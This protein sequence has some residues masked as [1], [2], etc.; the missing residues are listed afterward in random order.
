MSEQIYAE[1]IL[2]RFKNPRNKGKL[3]KFTYRYRELNSICGDEVEI[4][5][6]VRNNKI[7]NA[8]FN[9]DGCAISQ[10]S[11]DL[12]IDFIIGKNIEDIKKIDENFLINELI[13]IPISYRRILCATLSLKALKKA[14]E[15]KNE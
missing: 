7:E 1:I 2:N 5:L 8:K 9:G 4:F 3:D 13:K 11:A 10:A 14:L 6:E 15:K 12:L